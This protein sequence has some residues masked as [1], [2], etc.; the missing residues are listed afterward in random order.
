MELKFQ[1]K[2][3]AEYLYEN[4]RILLRIEK[5]CKDHGER[6]LEM[7]NHA[8]NIVHVRNAS[9]DS[10]KMFLPLVDKLK[11][12]KNIDAIADNGSIKLLNYYQQI[13]NETH[14]SLIFQKLINIYLSIEKTR[15][16]EDLMN[17]TSCNWGRWLDTHVSKTTDTARN[18][19]VYELA[20]IPETFDHTIYFVNDDCKLTVYKNGEPVEIKYS[21]LK[22]GS[23]YL[24]SLTPNKTGNYEVR[25]SFSQ[26]ARL[27]KYVMNLRFS[28]KFVVKE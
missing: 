16:N 11:E 3:T 27:H 17:V 24:I 22:K 23:V 10:S 19:E 26:S 7:K 15:L 13:F 1:R 20:V 25:G 28:D 4:D 5:E 21:I 2:L 8:S 14:D 18:G 9:I 6:F 12:E